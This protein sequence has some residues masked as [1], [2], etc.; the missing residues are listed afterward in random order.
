M[1]P[2]E[3]ECRQRIPSSQ[4]MHQRASDMFFKAYSKE[5]RYSDKLKILQAHIIL[6]I[7][8]PDGTFRHNLTERQLLHLVNNPFKWHKSSIVD[9]DLSALNN[10]TPGIHSSE[11]LKGEVKTG[12]DSFYKYYH[13]VIPGWELNVNGVPI[14]DTES[15][16][17]YNLLTID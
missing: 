17:R 10:L 3:V 2:Q 11:R 5:L 1:T 6:C 8:L 13:F 7:V 14:V 15:V 12:T 4:E 9:M 16:L